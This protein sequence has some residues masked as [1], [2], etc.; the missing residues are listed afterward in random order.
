MTDILGTGLA[1]PLGVDRRGGLALARD[2]DDVEQAISIILSTAPGERPMRPEFGCGVHDYVFDVVDAG[3]LGRMEEQ[4]RTA[5]SRWEPRIDVL[6]IDF[7]HDASA[8]GPLAVTIGYRMRATNDVR[9][10]VYPFYV[11][12]AEEA[13]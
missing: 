6:D 5:L 4:I 11:V 7:E 2:E 3:T 1:F 13:E 9:N 12:P 8:D 10:L